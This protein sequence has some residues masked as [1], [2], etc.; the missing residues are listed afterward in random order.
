MRPDDTAP[1]GAVCIPL[2]ARDGSVRAY[3]LVD[4]ADAD[5]VN[6]WHWSL[7]RGGYAVRHQMIDGVQR[8]FLLHREIL[9]MVRGDGLEGD[10]MNH[11]R[12]DCRRSNLRAITKKGNR[13]NVRAKPWSTSPYRGVCWDKKA[14]KWNATIFMN[15][16]KT[17]LG[18]FDVEADAAAASLSARQKLMP[19]ALD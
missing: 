9:G 14:G 17:H 10:H 5:F 3:A 8:A 7:H 4:P 16:K 11:D 12:L 13:Q 1:E 19:Y 15:G 18:Y 2:R 6:R